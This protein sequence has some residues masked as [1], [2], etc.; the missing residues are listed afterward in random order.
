M[1][2]IG[3]FGGFGAAALLAGL[4]LHPGEARAQERRFFQVAP[5]PR[6]D[7]SPVIGSGE[8]LTVMD[9]AAIARWLCPNG[10]TPLRGRPGRCDGRGGARGGGA[11]PDV[12][13]WHAGLPPPTHRQV[14]CPAGTVA[15]PARANPG[16]VRCMPA[17]AELREAAAKPEAAEAP[18]AAGA[19]TTDV[20]ETAE[21]LA[22]R[23]E[24]GPKPVATAAA[25]S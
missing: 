7:T 13:G 6:L 2:R 15:A 4:A 1:M 10:G 20:T 17:P 18:G 16:T 12:A 23:K 11:D 14:A 21:A 19:K 25:G 8:R 5:G 22:P 24:T 9:R 3:S